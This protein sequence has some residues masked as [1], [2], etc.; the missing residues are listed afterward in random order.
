MT[1]PNQIRLGPPDLSKSSN[2][3][4]SLLDGYLAN[5]TPSPRCGETGRKPT[6]DYED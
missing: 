5:G 2:L 3:H 6:K 1:R 4:G